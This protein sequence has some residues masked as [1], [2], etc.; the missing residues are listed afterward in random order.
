MA[1]LKSSRYA[2]IDTV[3]A[4]AAGGRAVTA[5]KLRRLPRT[6]GTAYLTQDRDR[7]DILAY[8][9]LA[10]ATRFWRIADANTALQAESLTATAGQPFLMPS[11]T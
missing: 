1:F 3:A 8:Q 6:T 11:A 9:Q 7:I 4:V 5:V 2:K 10:D